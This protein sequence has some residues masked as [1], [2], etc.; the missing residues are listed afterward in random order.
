MLFHAKILNVLD[1]V[2]QNKPP[3]LLER[4]RNACRTRHLSL[5]TE[6]AYV[7]WVR[8][9]VRYQTFTQASWMTRMT[10]AFLSYLAVEQPVAVFTQNQAYTLLSLTGAFVFRM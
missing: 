2:R 3:K 1:N 7:N 8:R 4:V 10:R 9:Y 6:K 5:R